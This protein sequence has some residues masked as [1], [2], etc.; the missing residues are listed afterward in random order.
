[1][2]L[3]FWPIKHFLT[4]AYARY[5]RIVLRAH[6]IFVQAD[7]DKLEVLGPGS[8]SVQMYDSVDGLSEHQWSDLTSMMSEDVARSQFQ[9]GCRL[10]VFM[11]NGHVASFG[12]VVSGRDL[13]EWWYPIQSE[14]FVMFSAYTAPAFRGQR[15]WGKIIAAAYHNEVGAGGQYYCDCNVA[16]VASRRQLLRSGFNIISRETRLQ[17]LR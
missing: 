12:W 6:Y 7:T 5:G 2:A 3:S 10:Y 16:N 4:R 8:G 11:A 9:R 13:T 1:M 17:P 14:D 15:L